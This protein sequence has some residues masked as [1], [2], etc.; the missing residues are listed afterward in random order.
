[1]P[2]PADATPGTPRVFETRLQARS[3]ELDAFDHVNHAVFLNWLEYAR[4]EALEAGGYSMA[5]L[6]ARGWAVVVAR[7]EIDFEKE[8]FLGDE[9]R[10]RTWVEEARKASMTLA[11]EVYRA[12]DGSRGTG[13][14]GTEPVRA[15][16][17][18]IVAVWLKNGRPRR[19]PDEVRSA[20]G[21]R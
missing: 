8:V 19:I 20:L 16:R 9:V 15:A 2:D 3:Y 10:I 1:M 12:A 6:A 14:T 21:M 17:A 11:Q 18:K 4:F 13:S 5:G 7:A